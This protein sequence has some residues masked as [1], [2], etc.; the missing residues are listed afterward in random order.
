MKRIEV[1]Y[2]K[3]ED[4]TS[5]SSDIFPTTFGF[6]EEVGFYGMPVEEYP[7]MVKVYL[8]VQC[9]SAMKKE[10]VGWSSLMDNRLML[11]NIMIQCFNR[12]EPE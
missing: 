2:W 4:T 10:A 9:I 7:D 6:V 5:F 3:V 12:G 1:L 8:H 11:H